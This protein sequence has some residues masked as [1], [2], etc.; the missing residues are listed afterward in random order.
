MVRRFNDFWVPARRWSGDDAVRA[1]LIIRLLSIGCIG[2]FGSAAVF[3]KLGLWPSAVGSS[4]LGMAWLGCM[5]AIRFGRSLVI[6]SHVAIASFALALV[7]PFLITARPHHD[8]LVWAVVLP[9][10]GA[11][12]LGRRG[13][14]TWGFGALVAVV[15]A[16]VL[17]PWV[18]HAADVP[19]YASEALA[20]SRVVLLVF[21]S[22]VLR[23][24][25]NRDDQRAERALQT[26]NRARSSFLATMSH[27]IRTPMNGVLGMT[28]VMLQ[29]KL[30]PEMRE[31]LSL[32]QRS[33]QSLVSL[34]NDILDFSKIEAGKLHLES[35][36]FD[37]ICL[38]GDLQQLFEPIALQKGVELDLST[39]NGVPRLLRGDSLR[40]GQVLNNL[41]NNAV[42]F[43]P[44]GKVSLRAHSVQELGTKLQV[45]FEIED[46]GVGIVP[47]VLPR[48]FTLF[49]QGDAGTTRRFGGTGLG[50]ALSQQL[51]GL[52]GGKLEVESKPGIG[53]VFRFS[54]WFERGVQA[55]IDAPSYTAEVIRSKYPVLVVDDNAINLRVAC[56]LLEKAGYQTLSATNGL[57]ALEKVQ[58]QRFALVLMDC[59]MPVMDGF[60]ATERIR[61][62]DGD[63][64]MTPIIALTAS[65][66]PEELEA[67]RR[68]GM[69]DCLTK[70]VSMK[71][72][73]RVLGQVAELEAMLEGQ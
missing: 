54:L 14:V 33:G 52:M 51:V 39:L 10:L 45:R 50:L 29:S 70:P 23:A 53:S 49:E 46:T 47:E 55:L 61:G 41:V 6:S 59:H 64:G 38:M 9:Q 66:M 69:N 44:R 17:H 62:L 37:L 40:L 15:A 43:T 12:M 35:N 72:L 30:E 57:E 5:L 4:G 21:L 18:P 2:M 1:T 27:E 32:I 19:E 16:L 22:L 65:A 63:V 7:L 36:D 60:E 71:M 68:A 73:Q 28:E 58:T 13:G 31:Q 25:F 26:A 24:Q 8:Q 34:I 3:A 20:T 48:L 67:C 11:L 42:K 56:G